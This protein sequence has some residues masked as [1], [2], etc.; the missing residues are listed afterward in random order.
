MDG[1]AAAVN[2][3]ARICKGEL[4]VTSFHSSQGG[5]Q[6]YGGLE[7]KLEFYKGF[8]DYKLVVPRKGDRINLV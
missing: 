8:L 2:F 6:R 5:F 1:T 4:C 7:K 3:K